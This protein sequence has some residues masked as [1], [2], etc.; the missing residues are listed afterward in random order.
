[1]NYC[2]NPNPESPTYGLELTVESAREDIITSIDI[3]G[4][5]YLFVEKCEIL[6]WFALAF[7]I[8]QFFFAFGKELRLRAWRMS[9]KHLPETPAVEPDNQEG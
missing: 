8:S 3:L 7:T 6:A 5:V 4:T 2:D 1:M 9:Q